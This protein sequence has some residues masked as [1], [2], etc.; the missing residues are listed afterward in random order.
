MDSVLGIE[1]AHVVRL[2]DCMSIHH[3]VKD[4]HKEM[5]LKKKHSQTFKTAL[6]FVSGTD[7][8]VS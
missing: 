5:Y 4:H 3:A 2:A 6:M 1:L 8:S 7:H